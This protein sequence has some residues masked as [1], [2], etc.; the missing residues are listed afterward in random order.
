MA[1][2]LL[3]SEEVFR[4][5]PCMHMADLRQRPSAAWSWPRASWKDTRTVDH[6][7]ATEAEVSKGAQA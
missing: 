7:A 2:D 4:R 6:A 1:V 3:G 5:H